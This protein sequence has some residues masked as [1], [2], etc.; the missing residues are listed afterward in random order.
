MVNTREEDFTATVPR[1]PMR[2]RIKLGLLRDGTIVGKEIQTIADNGAYANLGPEVATVATLRHDHLFR[3]QDVRSELYV[4]HTNKLPTGAF[5]G[6]GN[7]SGQ[8][9]MQQMVDMGAQALAMDPVEFLMRN[10]NDGEFTSQ[11]GARVL[12]GEVKACV[13]EAAGLIGWRDK[14]E[15]RT[16][17]RGLGFAVSVMVSGKR[18]FRNFDGSSAVVTVDIDGRATVWCGEGETGPGTRT[19]MAQIAA[20]ELGLSFADVTVSTADT[21]KTP[22]AFGTFASRATYIAGNA[23]RDAARRARLEVLETASDLLEVAASDLE[24][25]DGVIAVRGAPSGRT[26]TVAEA[27]SRRLFGRDGQPISVLGHWDPPSEMQDESYHGN[28]SGAYNFLACALEVEVDPE[29]GTFQIV[30]AA[31]A[32]DAGTIINPVG[33]EGQ[34]EGA[35]AQGLGYA[36]TESL[37]MEDGRIHNPNFSDYRIPSIADMPPLRQRF[38]QSYEPT[39]PFGA[40]GLGQVGLDPVAPALANA[41]A[42]ATGVRVTTLPILPEKILAGLRVGLE[43]EGNTS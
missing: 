8:W 14:R 6:F 35:F 38:V 4:V 25:K 40:K 36:K 34:N 27:V 13:R 23:V 1:M 5:R 19:V 15:R 21:E 33:A 17:N 11:Q 26:V 37:V 31:M 32:C 16:P 41:I 43:R 10:L 39:G 12:S 30:D 24:I 7:P 42:D 3:Y 20:E 18:H 28:E 29:T 2:I 9:A 22:H